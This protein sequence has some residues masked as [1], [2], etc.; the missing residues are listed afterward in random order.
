MAN[1]VNSRARE[2]QLRRLAQQHVCLTRQLV[3]EMRKQLMLT[4]DPNAM[5]AD[6]VKN[7][8]PN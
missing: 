7:R 3:A 5:N 2:Q 6:G 4:Q 8:P 1:D